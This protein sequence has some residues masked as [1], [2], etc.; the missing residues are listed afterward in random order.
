MLQLA[1]A[2][3]SAPCTT[4]CGSLIPHM[5]PCTIPAPRGPHASASV[6][7]TCVAAC[8]C[9]RVGALHHPLRLSYSAH[10]TLHYSCTSR[11]SYSAHRLR[12]PDRFAY[13]RGTRHPTPLLCSSALHSIRA[14]SSITR[15]YT[16]APA[17]C[18]L[19]S[20]RGRSRG[21]L[22][23]PHLFSPFTREV[24]SSAT[25]LCTLAPVPC[26]RCSRYSCSRLHLFS[27][28]TR[29]VGSS[30]TRL[31]PLLPLCIREAGSSATRLYTLRLE[32][33]SPVHACAC[34]LHALQFALALASVPRTT[35][36]GSPIP[37]VAWREAAHV[38]PRAAASRSLPCSLVALA[39]LWREAA[40]VPPR[41]A[42][43]RSLPCSLDAGSAGFYAGASHPVARGGA[44][45]V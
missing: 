17:H 30:A 25:R 1:L 42:A 27:P 31:A 38:L 16:R 9:A 13:F 24:G 15:L 7:C 35:H 10:G 45:A 36:C 43:S 11:P 18:F 34:A 39:T 12:D 22:A 4:H 37:H 23:P 26:T 8:T 5:V 20:P 28:F 29:E 2:L 32:C 19:C 21:C 14:G 3:A 44:C 6:L 40:R 33:H 41:A